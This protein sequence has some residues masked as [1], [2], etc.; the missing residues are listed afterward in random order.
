MVLQKNRV[1]LHKAEL[2]YNAM[3]M[4]ERVI[5]EEAA[6]TL[7]SFRSGISLAPDSP[8][9]LPP[10]E[11][12]GTGIARMKPSSLGTSQASGSRSSESSKGSSSGKTNRRRRR[13]WDQAR[14]TSRSHREFPRLLSKARIVSS[15]AD[16]SPTNTLQSMICQPFASKAAVSRV[17]LSRT[18][19]LSKVGT[20]LSSGDVS[21]PMEFQTEALESANGS[22]S[23]ETSRLQQLRQQEKGH[24]RLTVDESTMHLGKYVLL[25]TIATPIHQGSLSFVFPFPVVLMPLRLIGRAIFPY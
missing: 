12:L 19:L 8:I 6:I 7:A 2:R 9:S 15:L 20:W 14:M 3:K 16:I 1:V 23:G 24:W 13:F 22:A 17:T 25:L 18:T 5:E 21:K 4:K 11:T 10:E